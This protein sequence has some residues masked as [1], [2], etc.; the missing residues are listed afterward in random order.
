LSL[1]A[2]AAA[3]QTEDQGRNFD[4]VIIR[5]FIKNTDAKV[6]IGEALTEILLSAQ[7]D[8]LKDVTLNGAKGLKQPLPAWPV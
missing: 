4:F 8:M 2:N 6:W 7:N 3:R 5:T 1:F